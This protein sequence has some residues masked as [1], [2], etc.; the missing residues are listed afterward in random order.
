M[1]RKILKE[2]RKIIYSLVLIDLFIAYFRVNFSQDED[3]GWFLSISSFLNH[4]YNLYSEIFEIKDPLYFYS[5]AISISLFGLVGAFLIDVVLILVSAPLAF[6]VARSLNLS[7]N[8]SILSAFSFT[9][10]LTGFSYQSF[11]TQIFGIT[12]FL[13]A[14][15]L[16]LDKKYFWAGF[17]GMAVLGFKLPMAIFLLGSVPL[18]LYIKIGIKN[19]IR[20]FSGCIL[21]SIA[22]LLTLYSRSELSGY[23]AMVRENIFY[24]Q[25]YQ[26]VVGLPTGV[27]GHLAIWNGETGRAIMLIVTSLVVSRIYFKRSITLPMDIQLNL[28]MWGMTFS[29]FI[30]LGLTALWP[31]HMQI[32][33]ISAFSIMLAVS[34]LLFPQENLTT[35][36][37]NIPRKIQKHKLRSSTGESLKSREKVFICLIALIV[38]LNFGA[39]FSL[40]PKM[41]IDNWV[42]HSWRIPPELKLLNGLNVGDRTDIPFARL[43]MNDELALAG[44]LDHSKWRYACVRYGI[45]GGESKEIVDTFIKCLENKVEVITIS[46]MYTNQIRPGIFGEYKKVSENIIRKNFSCR[47]SMDGYQICIR[48]GSN[49]S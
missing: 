31:H 9:L 28:F 18:M 4:G 7:I 20:I 29:T 14:I 38:P 46:P 15:L 33:C 44:F 25:N 6:M 12:L 5:A 26:A 10:V 45:A 27:S 34:N 3:M 24:S 30:F 36:N 47:M 13:Y 49:I 21:F 22:F 1:I 37:S 35:L 42:N 8:A 11:R 2:D 19:W 41:S 40:K 16:M 39:E 48:N 17:V 23:I 32:L 43:G